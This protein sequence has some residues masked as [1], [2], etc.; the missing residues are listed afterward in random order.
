MNVS[1]RRVSAVACAVTIAV[2]LLVGCGSEAELEP[3]ATPSRSDVAAE[4][5]PKSPPALPTPVATTQIAP[6][7]KTRATA[8]VTPTAT[9]APTTAPTTAPTAAPT[10][11][12]T[13]L[14]ASEAD[15]LAG[16]IEVQRGGNGQWQPVE[17]GAML[18][19]GDAIRTSP[20]GQAGLSFADGSEIVL[21]GSTTLMLDRFFLRTQAEQVIERFGRMVLF[22]GSVAFN[23][24]PF[25]NVPSPWEFVTGSEII[26]IT[27]TSGVM[28]VGQKDAMADL[29]A[30]VRQLIEAG[31]GQAALAA[32]KAA[33]LEIPAGVEAALARGD[34]AGA[35]AA[36]G[37]A[38][39]N[40]ETKRD[41]PAG[42][43]A[44]LDSQDFAA[45]EAIAQAANFEIPAELQAAMSQGRSG[46]QGAQTAGD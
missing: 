30:N 14:P 28:A 20:D 39:Q 1:H 40:L 9:P 32:A 17:S 23:V 41:L 31:D 36:A 25:P 46:K 21:Q 5:A 44:A 29:P 18:W 26:G 4:Q 33:G 6:A 43:Q 35:A 37:A 16:T 42:M 11:E 38:N 19:P 8:R 7:A 2:A 12:P 10:P 27:G 24:K 45:A 15:V 13:P 22:A 3:S 34:Q